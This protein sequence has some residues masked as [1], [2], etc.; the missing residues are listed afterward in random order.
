MDEWET[1]VPRGTYQLDP[2]GWSTPALPPV[3]VHPADLK[4]LALH[5]D[6]ERHIGCCGVSW[7]RGG[8]NFVCANGHEVGW[9]W[10]DC[11]APHQ[12]RLEHVAVQESSQW[13]VSEEEIRRRLAA[14]AGWPERDTGEMIL[15]KLENNRC[16]METEWPYVWAVSE[17]DAGRYPL[18]EHLAIELGKAVHV[19]PNEPVSGLHPG[20]WL[21]WNSVRYRLPFSSLMVTRCVA[22]G[23]WPGG[24]TDGFWYANQREPWI[25]WYSSREGEFLWVCVKT[26][27][28]IARFRI[29]WEEWAVA[30][31]KAVDAAGS[32]ANANSV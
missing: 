3:V 17:K 5:P 10:T 16:L 26:T 30:W 24:T 11:M 15:P 20:A 25:E 21:V 7:G 1:Q 28:G 9:L 23:E 27:E 4:N 31:E 14:M 29:R 8:P 22:M 19:G 32:A 6:G 13:G 18:L 12:A 2:Q